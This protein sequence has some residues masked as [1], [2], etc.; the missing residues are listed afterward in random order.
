MPKCRHLNSN[1]ALDVEYSAFSS[2][3]PAAIRFSATFT[4]SSADF[5]APFCCRSCTALWHDLLVAERNQ[6]Q[7]CLFACSAR[8]WARRWLLP[9]PPTPSLSF[10]SRT[11]RSAVFF[12]GADF[13][14]RCDIR[15]HY[16]RFETG[17][18]HPAQNCERQLWPDAADIVDEQSEKIPLGWRH[19]S[20]KHVRILAHADA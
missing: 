6:R 3:L 19:E 14:N 15:I 4:S 18:A 17:H 16:R 1:W 13:R 12:Q 7:H 2:H 20:I 11:I 5:A 8:A 10:N 9:M